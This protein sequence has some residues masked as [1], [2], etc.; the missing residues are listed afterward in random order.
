VGALTIEY[1]GDDIAASGEQMQSIAAAVG[2]ILR[3]KQ[4]AEPSFVARLSHSARATLH[5]AGG[6]GR[7]RRK[8]VSFACVLALG[9]LVL[10]PA[11]YRVASDAV[12]E[13]SI[14]RA[15]VAPM[16]GF[17]KIAGVRPGDTVTQGQTLGAL[18]D[19]ELQLERMRWDGQ[20]TQLLREHREALASRERSQI[21]ILNSQIAQAEAQLELLDAQLERT[22]LVAPFAGIVTSGD[23]SQKM[24]APVERGNILFTVAPLDSYR[25]VLSVNE[26]DISELSEGQ[27]PAT[28]DENQVPG[29]ANW[30]WHRN[31]TVFCQCLLNPSPRFRQPK[32]GAISSGSRH[33][34]MALSTPCDPACRVSPR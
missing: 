11:D 17:I 14:Q 21:G 15:V 33:N 20:R 1:R 3:L 23:L 7:T 27:P 29:R 8:I 10:V 16:D 32:M 31:R 30:S 2:P 13:G 19:K 12:L 18:D 22:E 26:Q 6:G 4:Q 5:N 9:L 28:M 25:V 34:C 24:G